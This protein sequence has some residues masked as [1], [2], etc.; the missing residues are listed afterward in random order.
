MGLFQSTISVAV[1][2]R[3]ERQC[4]VNKK[5]LFGSVPAHSGEHHFGE[6]SG[7]NSGIHWNGKHRGGTAKTSNDGPTQTAI[8][9]RCFLQVACLHNPVQQ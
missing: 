4:L 9:H 6:H 1:V 8:A 7:V 5:T 3:R 2:G